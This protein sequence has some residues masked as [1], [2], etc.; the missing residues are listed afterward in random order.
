MK[1]V[2]I[3]PKECIT[4]E[5]KSRKKDEIIRELIELLAKSPSVK[6]TA[7]ISKSIFERERTMST[8]IGNGV[9]IPHGKSA[10][11]ARLCAA[12][13]IIKDGADFDSI[14]KKPAHIF[15]LLAS[16]EGPPGPHIKALSRISRMLNKTQF[17]EKLL[18]CKSSEEAV[19]AIAEEEKD[20]FE[21]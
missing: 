2:D 12:L 4:T 16:P 7:F 14:D 10:G 18:Q 5:L 20:Y 6:D 11:I 17:R 1:L 15:V 8:G 13:G 9:A 3:L 19:A 21:I